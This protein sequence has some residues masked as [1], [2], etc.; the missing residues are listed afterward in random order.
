MIETPATS[1][2]FFRSCPLCEGDDAEAWL[3]K[4]S[5]RLVRCRGCSMVF[6]NPVDPE[7]ASGRFYDRLAVPFY[8]SPDK[9]QSDYA[10]VRF[11]REL[12]LFRSFCPSGRVLDVGCSTG[13]FLFQ[14]QSR[15]AGFYTVTGT[16][17]A[18]AALDHCES[19]GIEVIRGNF[20]EFDFGA[21]QFAAITF[22]A[23][24]EH[25]VYP[26]RFL[27]KAASL[28]TPGGFCFLLVPNLQSLAVRLLGPKYRYIMPDHVN[29][30]TSSTLR[31][32]GQSRDLFEVAALG[33]FHFN[34]LVILKDF[35]RGRERVP[36]EE[37]ARL[38]KR[39]TILKQS[40]FLRPLKAVY[41]GVERILG[42]LMLAD[43][44]FV[45][46]RRKQTEGA[47]KTRNPGEGSI[48]SIDGQE[49]SDGT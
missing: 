39:T 21:R 46:L 28:L 40:A 22:W 37:R 11:E 23:V 32:F 18:G 16:D 47:W 12:R 7:M 2:V 19:R 27:Q 14:L 1:H 26:R 6:A 13:A 10:P 48:L 34:P 36:D 38:L 44:L 30:F 8:L 33:S 35:V 20:L 5:L 25:L 45:V 41:H 9:L 49:R 4:G 15:Y 3:E 29:Y 42:G 31:S 17:V 24:M 43:N